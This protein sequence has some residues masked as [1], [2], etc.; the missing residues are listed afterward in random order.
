MKKTDLLKS[1]RGKTKE[2]LKEELKTN[3]LSAF[4]LRIQ[5][6]NGSLEK[7]HTIRENRKNIARVKT[8]LKELQAK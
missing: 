6:F 1:Y 4:T 2:E 3:Q 8:L 7:T 5:K